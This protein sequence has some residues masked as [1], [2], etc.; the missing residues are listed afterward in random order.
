[1]S[2]NRLLSQLACFEQVLGLPKGVPFG[3]PK[4]LLIS[5]RHWVFPYYIYK[6]SLFLHD[7]NCSP[8]IV[9]S[10]TLSQFVSNSSFHKYIQSRDRFTQPRGLPQVFVQR[11]TFTSFLSRPYNY[12]PIVILAGIRTPNRIWG[13]LRFLKGPLTVKGP[14]TSISETLLSA[15]FRPLKCFFKHSASQLQSLGLGIIFHFVLYSPAEPC[16]FSYTSFV[17]ILKSPVRL[18][19]LF[20]GAF[21]SK[22]PQNKDFWNIG[23]T[24]FN[25]VSDTSFGS[26]YYLK[27]LSQADHCLRNVQ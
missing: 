18:N 27:Q 1:M 6:K 25:H 4:T 2:Q 24:S 15:S 16:S 21:K 23:F 11:S 10:A 19:R 20:K 13:Y 14:K 22:D 7:L 12:V 3:L 5:F 17:S 8:R 9:D 26:W